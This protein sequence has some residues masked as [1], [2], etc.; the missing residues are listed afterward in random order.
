[1]DQVTDHPEERSETRHTA[2]QKHPAIG[3]TRRLRHHPALRY[4]TWHMLVLHMTSHCHVK[5]CTVRPPAQRHR[6]LPA[7]FLHEARSAARARNDRPAVIGDFWSLTQSQIYRSSLDVRAGLVAPRARRARTATVHVDRAAPAS[8]HHRPPHIR[9]P[10]L[11]PHFGH[12]ATLALPAHINPHPPPT[13]NTAR[14]ICIPP[15]SHPPPRS[16]SYPSLPPPRP[17]PAHEN[18]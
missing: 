10:L 11:L 9:H 3:T 16:S 8:G 6:R 17:H 5:R 18:P 4:A 12:P 13:T 1:M 7:R 2:D 15:A 14:D